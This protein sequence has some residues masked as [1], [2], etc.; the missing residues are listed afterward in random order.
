M[1]NIFKE[2][3]K[4]QILD[5]VDCVIKNLDEKIEELFSTKKMWEKE[6]FKIIN[7]VKKNE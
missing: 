2:L 4:K 5:V 3:N 7:E 1:T 6:R